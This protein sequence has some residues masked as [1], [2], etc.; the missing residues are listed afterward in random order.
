VSA[1][2]LECVFIGLICPANFVPD[3]AGN[4]CIPI[5]KECIKGFELNDDLTACVPEPGSPVPFP[6]L[7]AAV[8]VSFLVL[9]SYLKEKFF[10]KVYTCLLAIIGSFEII[11][12][13][14]MVALSGYNGETAI[15]GLCAVGFVCL[16]ISNIVFLV[17]FQREVV[18]KDEDF[19]K[20]LFFHPKTKVLLPVF[21]L[22]LNFKSSKIIYSGF[23]GLESS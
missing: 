15:C 21:C 4:G 22:L 8:F 14:L 3:A 20:W 9:G 18:A 7:I 23:Y 11:M 12:Y 1:D 17:L 19:S 6:F 13:A 2:G 10:T 5:L 16:L